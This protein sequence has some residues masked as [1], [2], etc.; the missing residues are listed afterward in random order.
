LFDRI[1]N[2]NNP[3]ILFGKLKEILTKEGEKID[4]S[5]LDTYF[6]ALIGDPSSGGDAGFFDNS[7]I[8]NSKTFATKLLGFE[9]EFQ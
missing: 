2:G 4:A 3:N 1:G 6:A 8:A 5:D 7:T 9:D